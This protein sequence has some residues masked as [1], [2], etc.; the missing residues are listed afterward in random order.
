MNAPLVT[1]L[2]SENLKW[3][4]ENLQLKNEVNKAQSKIIEVQSENLKLYQNLF[5]TRKN[6]SIIEKNFQKERE[7]MSKIN[8]NMKIKSNDDGMTPLHKAAKLGNIEACKFLLEH[9]VD[10]NAKGMCNRFSLITHTESQSN[11]TFS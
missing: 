8:K 2:Q 1:E 7:E 4:E 11:Y 3:Q 9:Q 5:D 6:F 10:K